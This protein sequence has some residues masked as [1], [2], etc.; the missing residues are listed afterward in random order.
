MAWIPIAIQGASMLAGFIGGQDAKAARKQEAARRQAAANAAADEMEIQ[1]VE[2]VG[3]GY[4]EAREVGRQQQ[5]AI[6]RIR[7]LAASHGGSADAS[8]V[9][10][11]GRAKGDQA[12]RMAVSVYE[13]E[14]KARTLRY[15]AKVARVTGDLDAARMLDEAKATGINT[16]VNTVQ[17][18]SSLYQRFNTPSA[19]GPSNTNFQSGTTGGPAGPESSQY[20]GAFDP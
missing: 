18:G 11:I 20:I 3:A 2:A 16:V 9:N 6:D 5:F 1:A 14:T 12:Y 4:R 19:D 15:Q 7:V 10:L 8:V 17:M 13:G